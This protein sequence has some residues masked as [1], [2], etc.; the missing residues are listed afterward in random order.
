MREPHLFLLSGEYET[1]PKAELEAVLS[2][3]DP[4]PTLKLSSGR[5]VVY[6]TSRQAAV[7]A[8][9][10]TSYTKLTARLIGVSETLEDKI[11]SSIDYELL[12]ILLPPRC[13]IAVRGKRI[14]GVDIRKTWVEGRI[15]AEVLRRI[16]KLRVDL[17]TPEETIF[18]VAEPERT[19]IGLLRAVKP[20][21]FFT[22]RTAGRRPFSLPSAM[23]PDFAR[24]M[25]NLARVSIGGRI[26]DPFAGTGG[27]M[28]EA[29]LLGYRVYGVELKKWIALG[30]LRNLKHYLPGCE[31]MVVGDSRSL[32][33]RRCFN[34]VVTDP[35]YGRSTIVPESS[36]ENLLED[37]LSKVS[38]FLVDDARIVMAVPS[39]YPIEETSESMGFK[40]LE[41]HL[42][43]VH[44]SL[45]RKVVV[46]A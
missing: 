11:P 4:E 1:L 23:Q 29:G 33:F 26:L 34:G 15:G 7:Q 22:D 46:L 10:R 3:F 41:T 35:P 5:V 31:H 37:F 40:V 2:I 42:A 13:S 12:R 44:G 43:R 27:I 9:E 18:F 28:I 30:G 32:M 21:R 19:W 20:R 8:V 38:E 24:C 17:K 16:P 36:L 45:V 25:V 14:G 39:E 6:E